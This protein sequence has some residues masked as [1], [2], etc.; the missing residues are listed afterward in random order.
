M[1]RGQFIQFA[2]QTMTLLNPLIEKYGSFQAIPEKHLDCYY[3][4]AG[5]ANDDEDKSLQL[6]RFLTDYS[7]LPDEQAPIGDENNENEAKVE[8]PQEGDD[9]ET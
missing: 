5:I 4:I 8:G 7:A 9:D 2:K 6:E 1:T 3:P